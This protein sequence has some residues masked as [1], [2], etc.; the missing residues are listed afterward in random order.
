LAAILF[1][2]TIL[3]KTINRHQKISK[4]IIGLEEVF[5]VGQDTFFDSVSPTSSFGVTFEDD[6]TTGYLYALN[7]DQDTE[8]LDA[9]HIY[10]VA[11]VIDKDK[12]SKLQI[13][14]SDNGLIASILINS[15]CHAIFDFDTKAGYCR[16]G[17][18]E[19]NGDWIE[20]K[21]RVLTDDLIDEIFKI[22]K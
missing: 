3:I 6:L 14:W 19:S 10:N 1:N 13:V 20:I 16:N 21:E 15:Y 7:I 9:L 2:T 11:D 4:M 17:F 18:P 22:N 8:I 5:T 12:P